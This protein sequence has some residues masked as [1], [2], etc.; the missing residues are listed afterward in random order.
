MTFASPN[1]EQPMLHL[2]RYEALFKLIDDI[3]EFDDVAAITKR[4][5]TQWKYFA[6]VAA[7]RLVVPNGNVYKVIDGVRGEARIDNVSAMS[8]W[9]QYHFDL[10]RPH[11]I[12]LNYPDGTVDAPEHL[13]GKGIVDVMVLPFTRQ[14]ECLG[15]LSVA[16]R[17]EP[18]SELDN[19]F[20]RIFGKHLTDR[21]AGIILRRQTHRLLI[22]KAT[23]DALTGLLNRGTIVDWL[24]SKLSLAK[25]SGAP[26]SVILVDIDFFKHVNDHYGHSAGDAVLQQVAQ[27]LQDQTRD[28]DSLGRYGGEEF[29]VVLSPCDEDAVRLTA[30]RFRQAIAQRPFTL[31]TKSELEL[32]L[33]ISLGTACTTDDLQDMSVE[34]LLK[35]ADDALY[36][37]KARGRNCVTAAA[38]RR[39]TTTE[40]ADLLVAKP[41]V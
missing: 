39:G 10:R 3:Q 22:E 15:L 5:A 36:E 4:V 32:G 12:H 17:N 40:V 23:H 25:R 33:T 31:P 37:S 34:A 16:A 6:N 18:F 35:L 9:D 13:T 30:E 14:G 38:P 27:R 29:L 11:L 1:T 24:S 26:L 41:M 20:I 21:L 28:G 8:A 2:V 7:W 19:K